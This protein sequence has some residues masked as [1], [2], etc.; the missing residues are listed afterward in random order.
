MNKLTTL[1]ASLAIA[2]MSFASTANSIEYKVGVT[3]QTSAYFANVEETLKTTTA[4]AGARTTDEE[5]IAA[6]NY[7]SLFAELAFDEAYGLTIGFE[8]TPDALE[9][10]DEKRDIANAVGEAAG[11]GN[12]L[13]SGT[14]SIDGSI[15]DL[16]LAYVAMPVGENGF[17]VKAGYG[18]ATLLTKEV[19]ATGSAYKDV[20][21][22]YMAMGA[23]YDHDLGDMAFIRVEAMY[24]QFDDIKVT[25]SESDEVLAGSFNK[26]TG[27]LGGVAAKLSLGLQF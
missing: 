8:F 18:T 14:Q 22:E 19:L 20:D 3:G 15:N 26:I 2:A 25:G 11:V 5:V 10:P 17:Y 1:V 12:A 27:E 23:G 16:M 6:F 13:D 21:L 7:L 9:L 4:T 24:N